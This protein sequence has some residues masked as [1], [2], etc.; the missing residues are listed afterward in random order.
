MVV[1]AAFVLPVGTVSRIRVFAECAG[2][3]IAIAASTPSRVR[4]V[5]TSWT[6]LEFFAVEWFPTVE[7]G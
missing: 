2:R 7:I 3:L 6:E 1:T 4:P 5:G